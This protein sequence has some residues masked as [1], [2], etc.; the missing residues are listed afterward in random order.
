MCRHRYTLWSPLGRRRLPSC[1][2]VLASDL[3]NHSYSAS[4]E[5]LPNALHRGKIPVKFTA[6]ERVGISG[7]VAGATPFQRFPVGT[8][9]QCST[10]DVAASRHGSGSVQNT[11]MTSGGMVIN[12]WPLLRNNASTCSGRALRLVVHGRRGGEVPVCLTTLVE[13][14]QQRRSSPV[15]LEVLTAEAPAPCP[16]A[17]TWLVPL[18]LWPG[19]HA[20]VDA[21]AIRQRLRAEGKEV[22][23]LPFLGAWHHWWD[24]V[25][26]ALAGLDSR[27][28]VLVHHPLRSGV[29]DRFLAVLADR[30]ALPLLSFD[31]LE[32]L[33]QADPEARPVPLTLAPN[34]MTEALREAGGLPPLLEHSLTRQALIELLA[35]LP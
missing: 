20:R 23:M 4:S 29:A 2:S 16:T 8:A 6:A 11:P 27:R 35:A 17:S 22:T 25:A 14:L 3:A 1:Q 9:L 31:R 5:H 15:Q 30:L 24:A 28:H 32:D 19:A 18:L 10:I 21:P 33:R 13:V 34:R 26:A 12:P 7:A